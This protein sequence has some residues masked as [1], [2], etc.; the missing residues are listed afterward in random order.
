VPS[1]Q[2]DRAA[3]FL[4]ESGEIELDREKL[5]ADLREALRERCL[6]EYVETEF[7]RVMDAV[8]R[9]SGGE[10]ALAAAQHR[11]VLMALLGIPLRSSARPRPP[12]FKRPPT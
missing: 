5:D 4:H 3:D 9:V 12:A 7:T 11:A 2:D 8:F 10:A 6:P 1:A